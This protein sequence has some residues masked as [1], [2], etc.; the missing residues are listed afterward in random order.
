[1]NGNPD[2]TGCRKKR[3]GIDLPFSL[4][5]YGQPEKAGKFEIFWFPN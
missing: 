2:P 5:G 1:V 3:R 4:S